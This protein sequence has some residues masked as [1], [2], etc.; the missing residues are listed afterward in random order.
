MA[1]KQEKIPYHERVAE[2]VIKA[3]EAG[4]A[5][6]IKPWQAGERPNRPTNGLTG[7]TYRGWNSIYLAMKQEGDDARWCTYKQA[8]ELGAQVR[9]GEKG[10]VIQYWQFG[11]KRL[12]KD[13][14]G[15]PILDQEGKKQYKNITLDRPKVFHAVVFNASQIDGMPPLPPRKEIPDWERH[16]QAEELLTA[17][18]AAIFHDQNDRAY[19]MS[20]TDQIHLPPKGQFPSADQYYATAIHELGHWTGHASRLDRDLANPFGS[21]AYAKEELRAEIASYML[22]TELG[23]GHDPGQHITYIGSWIK[24][25]KED[26]AEL[27]RASRDAQQIMDYVQSL[28]QTQEE[29]IDQQP[30]PEK[31]IAKEVTS[32]NN[33]AENLEKPEPIMA[34]ELAKEKTWL[35][36]PYAE[37]NEAKQHGA[38]WDR[39]IKSWYAP[40]G[41]DLAPLQKWLKSE[42]ALSQTPPLAPQEEFANALTAAGLQVEGAPIMDGQ[43]HRVPVEGDDK[44]RTSGA[45][46]GYL[47]GHPAG[48]IQNFKTGV[49]TN[50]KATGQNLNA[51]EIAR[52]ERIAQE[53]RKARAQERLEAYEA[54]SQEATTEWASLPEAPASHDYLRN[55]KLEGYNQSFGAKLDAKGNLVVPVQDAK[56][57]IW[58]LQRIS[59]KGQKGFEKDGRVA[60]CFHVIGGMDALKRQPA[61]EPLMISTGFATAATVHLA[62][63][64]P[65]IAA[66]QDSNL[67][68]VAQE[69]KQLFPQRDIIIFGDD[70]RHL[71]NRKPPLPNSG[72][73]KAIEAA[74]TVGGKAVFPQFTR[75]E[76]GSEF[77]DFADLNKARG[78]EAVKRQVS[79]ASQDRT[80]KAVGLRREARAR[81]SKSMAI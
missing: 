27:F 80:N 47:D 65:V 41:T 59:I 64:K 13:D 30:E 73:V 52:L 19:Y 75:E 14:L 22:G 45:Y 28:G 16:A 72:R 38:K 70:D 81:D 15:K 33:P 43:M 49:K 78:L 26:P 71:P 44:G 5:P 25:L 36:V 56:G 37:K 9:K 53:K 32:V 20:S 46:K 58:S 8:T 34:E 29:S 74:E 2:E 42:T 63:N 68:E 51:A 21:V 18:Q 35:T 3:L 6:W 40:T 11:E 61:G 48:F 62:S 54:K 55:K 4:T 24:V 67:K 7:Q 60:G 23:I 1:A 57:K 76:Q 17:S 39:S 77:T 10:S 12:M 69:L 66:L 79:V 31:V 50:W